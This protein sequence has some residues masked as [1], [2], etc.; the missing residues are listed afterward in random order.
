MNK[1][2]SRKKFKITYQ[3][4]RDYDEEKQSYNKENPIHKELE[5]LSKLRRLEQILTILE[6]A[7]INSS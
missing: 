5:A 6:N 4:K 3:I 7:Q 2:T 1:K